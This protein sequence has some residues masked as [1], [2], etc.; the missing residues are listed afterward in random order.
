VS[1]R[2]HLT[3][4]SVLLDEWLTK[5]LL[6]A[7]LCLACAACKPALSGSLQ[8]PSK[9][10]PGELIDEAIQVNLANTGNGSADKVTLD[11]VLSSDTDIPNTPAHLYNSSTYT[12]DMLLDYWAVGTVPANQSISLTLQVSNS[13]P[14]STPLGVYYL[15]A[16]FHAGDSLTKTEESSTIASCKLELLCPEMARI[17]GADAYIEDEYPPLPPRTM[18][19][20][21]NYS[22]GRLP[23]QISIQIFECNEEWVCEL[24]TTHKSPGA[25]T[26]FR[27]D[28]PFSIGPSCVP[29]PPFFSCPEPSRIFYKAILTSYY[30]CGPIQEDTLWLGPF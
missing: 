28:L 30:W 3:V 5:V 8:C 10:Y 19:V 13:I 26:W 17:S 2:T 18:R 21:W 14:Y 29:I 11:L 7:F 20:T 15:G 22:S 12:E 27:F 16:I 9:A 6:I 24:Y 1:P 23:E 25:A 4:G